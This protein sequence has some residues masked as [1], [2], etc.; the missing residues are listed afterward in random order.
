MVQAAVAMVL[1][2][3]AMPVGSVVAHALDSFAC[4]AALNVLPACAV[5]LRALAA[6]EQRV[7][8]AVEQ[9]CEQRSSL[10]PYPAAADMW[11]GLRCSWLLR[12]L[13]GVLWPA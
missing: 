8:P 9:V 2:M 3:G 4:M 13:W 12:L 6:Q 1:G 7:R 5:V 11:V 10:A